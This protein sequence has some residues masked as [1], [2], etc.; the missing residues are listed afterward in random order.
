MTPKGIRQLRTT[1]KGAQSIFLDEKT[2]IK[3]GDFIELHSDKGGIWVGCV[4]E[5]DNH[6]TPEEVSDES[7]LKI[8]WFLRYSD[9]ILGSMNASEN[10]LLPSEDVDLG[11]MRPG[12]VPDIFLKARSNSSAPNSNEAAG[13]RECHEEGNTMGL[14]ERIFLA[15]QE[16]W[17][18]DVVQVGSAIRRV[19]VAYVYPGCPPPPA[20]VAH[21]WF[22]QTYQQKF[23]KTLDCHTVPDSLLNTSLLV[24]QDGR[25]LTLPHASHAARAPATSSQEPTP[26]STSHNSNITLC[27]SKVT[28][29]KQKSSTHN[30]VLKTSSSGDIPEVVIS[31]SMRSIEVIDLTEECDGDTAECVDREHAITSAQ[32]CSESSGQAAHGRSVHGRSAVIGTSLL[33][34]K[35]LGESKLPKGPDGPFAT[36]M[37]NKTSPVNNSKQAGCNRVLL[38]LSLC[39]GLGSLSGVATHGVGG[40]AAIKTQWAV[41]LSRAAA[42]TFKNNHREAHVWNLCLDRVYW[43]MVLWGKATVKY[44]DCVGTDGFVGEDKEEYE[45]ARASLLQELD[46]TKEERWR[47]GRQDL[48]ERLHP[49]SY[50]V[51]SAEAVNFPTWRF[52]SAPAAY[53]PFSTQRSV[54]TTIPDAA[55]V[56]INQ[57]AP[58]TFNLQPPTSPDAASSLMPPTNISTAP[59]TATATAPLT[60]AALPADIPQSC[61]IAAGV[62]LQVLVG[63]RGMP[64]ALSASQCGASSGASDGPSSSEQVDLA[65]SHEGA[66]KQ[67]VTLNPGMEIEHGLGTLKS[68]GVEVHHGAATLNHHGKEVEYYAAEVE[69]GGPR[70]LLSSSSDEE[71]DGTTDTQVAAST[72]TDA[73]KTTDGFSNNVALKGGWEGIPKAQQGLQ[74]L[75]SAEGSVRMAYPGVTTPDIVAAA[76]GDAV[77]S[78]RAGGDTRLSAREASSVASAACLPDRDF[79]RAIGLDKSAADMANIRAPR[80]GDRLAAAACPGKLMYEATSTPL[81]LKAL[82]AQEMLQ[83]DELVARDRLT[84]VSE[85]IRGSSVLRAC[86]GGDAAAQNVEV[87]IA[88][89]RAK[90][91]CVERFQQAA[92]AEAADLGAERRSGKGVSFYGEGA[93]GGSIKRRPGKGVSF[94]GE[95]AEGGSIK[96]RRYCAASKQRSCRR[97]QPLDVDQEK[98]DDF[99]TEEEF[100]VEDIIN[101]RVKVHVTGDA[102]Q[103]DPKYSEG[104][105]KHHLQESE[106]SLEFLVQY[107]D[108]PGKDWKDQK[109]LWQSEESLQ[110]CELRLAQFVRRWN[111][112]RVIPQPHH[113][114]DMVITGGPPCQGISGFNKDAVRT[115]ILNCP[116]N[117]V[118]RTVIKIISFLKPAYVVIE[119]V[120]D[121]CKRAEGLYLRYI[122]AQM[123][124]LRY[125]AAMYGVAAGSFG[126][127][128]GRYRMLVLAARQG[129]LVPPAPLPTHAVCRFQGGKAKGVGNSYIGA[130]DFPE[131]YGL[132]DM[133]LMQDALSDLGPRDNFSTSSASQ[134]ST[135]P[136]NAFQLLLRRPPPRGEATQWQ[137]VLE[138]ELCQG[139][140]SRELCR[141]VMDL[142]ARGEEG[143]IAV[144][145][146]VTIRKGY[147]VDLSVKYEELFGGESICNAS[148]YEGEPE[149]RA[150]WA[151]EGSY[152]EGATAASEVAYKSVTPH[153]VEADR[154]EVKAAWRRT[155]QVVDWKAL[156]PFTPFTPLTEAAETESR[157]EGSVSLISAGVELMEDGDANTAAATG[158]DSGDEVLPEDILMQMIGDEE[159]EEEEEREGLQLG[160]GNGE[161]VEG[162][163]SNRVGV[164]QKQLKRDKVQHWVLLEQLLRE[165]PLQEAAA[166]LQ[167]LAA[168]QRSWFSDLGRQLAVVARR[169]VEEF[170]ESVYLPVSQMVAS[171]SSNCVEDVEEG[172]PV[173]AAASEAGTKA[174]PSTILEG[175]GV[176]QTHKTPHGWGGPL[177]GEGALPG[178]VGLLHGERASGPVLEHF[179]CEDNLTPE[180]HSMDF[181]PT[182]AAEAR[183]C[184][185]VGAVTVSRGKQT[186]PKSKKRGR[187]KWRVKQEGYQRLL[188]ETKQKVQ[189]TH[190]RKQV[191]QQQQPLKWQPHWWPRD[192]RAL[193]EE[194]GSKPYSIADTH[195]GLSSTT[196]LELSRTSIPPPLTNHV[197]LL[198]YGC[199]YLRTLLLPV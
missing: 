63:T 77:A 31:E 70:L 85:R 71:G 199:D 95:G 188:Q 30:G 9:T 44:G 74:T 152:V 92:A 81:K 20:G 102:Y 185:V 110:G 82:M 191:K 178:V 54:P 186:E 33:K 90:R 57:T 138:A 130:S 76:A 181:V 72:P 41:D 15:V 142:E 14:P 17:P 16:E 145:Q 37:S 106:V 58:L 104:L 163:V 108:V 105:L 165:M 135:G 100:E 91:T 115:E 3:V 127:P 62:S 125:Q 27:P 193:L 155:L 32:L 121:I 38:E 59:S 137:R 122:M 177:H 150:C 183:V 56:V 133:V 93:E 11:P 69:L 139:V 12:L 147:V 111:W 43:L 192:E 158:G 21:Y 39:C 176:N 61:L 194:D 131:N 4:C 6:D 5:I 120:S 19:I 79:I 65:V 25:W 160:P 35:G 196:S 124:S 47:Q 174:V 8:L 66:S 189:T 173:G 88:K 154:D 123:M 128:Q 187:G 83:E 179:T 26:Q 50:S 89:R 55:N 87:P 169:A 149:L 113:G 195:R 159:E 64:Q 144:G 148:G 190:C 170:R 119:Q 7:T 167:Y 114:K 107:A 101:V 67:D 68:P 60:S 96:R 75:A 143:L 146:V 86:V 168:Q 197:S 34:R 2:Q 73:S 162:D 180:G 24:E 97:V 116:K 132:W 48:L 156:A 84:A 99:D 166:C 18:P 151:S 109:W 51:C 198:H 42:M 80:L 140:P 182:E 134:Y 175:A 164:Q 1:Y 161:I 129:E 29:K 52:T 22:D 98:A 172:A 171:G 36:T 49:E 184:N 40:N 94:Y 46:R 157:R 45:S 112:L 28:N 13:S 23:L 126:V 103:R 10:T 53:R 78:E 153:G 136:Q 117:G 118:I 141:V